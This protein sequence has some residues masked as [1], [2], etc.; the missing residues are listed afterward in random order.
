MDGL[1]G[2]GHKTD[3]PFVSVFDLCIWFGIERVVKTSSKNFSFDHQS[4]FR[5]LYQNI[6][7]NLDQCQDYHRLSLKENNPDKCSENQ[8]I[9]TS[10]A[11]PCTERSVKGKNRLRRHEGKNNQ[12]KNITLKGEKMTNF[13]TEIFFLSALEKDFVH[14]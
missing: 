3:I 5:F 8:D 7:T 9:K 4:Y 11:N 1:F 14:R 10:N 2:K 13:Q 6:S 12:Q